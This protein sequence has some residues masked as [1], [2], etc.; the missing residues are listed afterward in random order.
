M[1][2]MKLIIA[3]ICLGCIH[4]NG[5]GQDRYLHTTQKDSITIMELLDSFKEQSEKLTEADSLLNLRMT[6][7]WNTST[8]NPY[9]NT[10]KTYPF[11]IEFSDSVYASPINRAKVVTSHY[12]WRNRRPHKGIDIDLVTGDNVMS[13]LDGKV[14][15]VKYHS[16]HGRV[17][18]IRHFNGLETVYAHLSK[19]LVKV[20][21]T[22]KKGQIIGKGGTTGNARGSHL[23]LEV[24]YKGVYI[25]PEYVFD[26]GEDNKIKS[27][28]IW[29]TKKWATPYVHNSKR[30][31]KGEL[32][33]TYEE[34]IA[35]KQ[36]QT[37]IYVV[38]RGDTLSKISNKYQVS[39]RSLCRTNAI[40]KTS[41]LK[42]GQKLVL[43][44]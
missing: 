30:Q 29:V 21:D 26:F 10:I 9:K 32:C 20:N 33:T 43:N 16:G 37:Q 13:M 3:L 36:E 39:I 38:R 12:G 25:N 35:S 40:A 4:I 28:N 31:T 15:Y 8:Y 7:R 44:P 14:R 6:E 1:S 42:V 5:H 19:Q 24:I 18:V 34:A 11:N 22:V 17:I 2:S 23:H 41:I 27:K